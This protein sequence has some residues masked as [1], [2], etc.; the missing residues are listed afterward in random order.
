MNLLIQGPVVAAFPLHFI[1]SYIGPFTEVLE[2]RSCLFISLVYKPEILHCLIYLST[3]PLSFFSLAVF[4]F[5]SVMT[6]L[7]L[8]PPTVT[9]NLFWQICVVESS[10]SC[11]HFL[12]QNL[13]FSPALSFASLL[14]YLPLNL[15]TFLLFSTISDCVMS[16]SPFC[17]GRILKVC[18]SHNYQHGLEHLSDCP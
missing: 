3:R 5:L 11:M 17:Q 12:L 15:S 10:V 14:S 18:W 2:L 13:Y 8:S 6:S 16:P 9:A 7:T 1:C 4:T